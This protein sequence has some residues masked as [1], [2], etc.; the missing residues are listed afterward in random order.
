MTTTADLGVPLLSSQ[1]QTP[2]IIH[3]EAIELLC[4]LQNGVISAGDKLMIQVWKSPELSVVVP[5]RP[6]GKISVPLLDDV[7]AEGFTAEELNPTPDEVRERLARV[8]A[9]HKTDSEL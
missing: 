9:K 7:Q 6:D 4:M 5:V 8:V 3:N 1:Q 2:E